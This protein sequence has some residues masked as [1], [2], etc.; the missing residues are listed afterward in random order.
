MTPCRRC[1]DGSRDLRKWSTQPSGRKVV[2]LSDL[3]LAVLFPTCVL[4]GHLTATEETLYPPSPLLRKSQVNGPQC[5]PNKILHLTGKIQKF[6]TTD[7]GKERQR[8]REEKRK[9]LISNY[10][11]RK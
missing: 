5:L 11:W 6:S 2:F 3:E 4:K 1:Q 7:P 9:E 8:R 10:F